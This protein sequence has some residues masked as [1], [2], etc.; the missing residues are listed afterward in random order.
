MKQRE[1]NET[2][3]G[4]RKK[5]RKKERRKER[6]NEREWGNGRERDREKGD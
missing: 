6:E 3:S 1:E 4:E 2:E 5:E